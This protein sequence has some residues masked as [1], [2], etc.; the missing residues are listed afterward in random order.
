MLNQTSSTNFRFTSL[1]GG[2]NHG[3]YLAAQSQD[4]S[5]GPAQIGVD[6]FVLNDRNGTLA[7]FQDPPALLNLLNANGSCSFII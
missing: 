2:S 4:S 6:E 3:A 7:T 1:G 5:A